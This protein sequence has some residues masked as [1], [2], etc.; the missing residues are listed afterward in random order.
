MK[1]RELILMLA[2]F[3]C[4]AAAADNELT[5]AQS[6]EGWFLLFDGKTLNNW[7]TSDWQLSKKPVEDGSIN[8]HG[9]GAYMMVH[10]QQWENFI[11]ALDFKISP[12]CN[13]GI[14]VRTS[15]VPR[16]P[17]SSWMAASSTT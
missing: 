9:A 15:P 5:S 6:K 3:C 14:F 8:P 11:L 7:M 10:E 4:V 12:H 16:R 2:G 17:R 13:S 1:T